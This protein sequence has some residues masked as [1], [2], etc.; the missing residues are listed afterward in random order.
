M[1]VLAWILIG[2]VSMSGDVITVNPMV[3]DTRDGCEEKR[4]DVLHVDVPPTEL[5]IEGWNAYC[6]PYWNQ[7]TGE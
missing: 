2:A 7:E 4:E 5:D 3:F 6:I 1:D